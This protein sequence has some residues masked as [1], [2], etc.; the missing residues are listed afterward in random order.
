MSEPQTDVFKATA[1]RCKVI[2]VAVACGTLTMV[3]ASYAPLG[4]RSLNIAAILAVAC[5]NA[6]LVSGYLMHLL[7]ERKAIL[8]VLAFTAVF[9]IGLMGL[10]IWAHGD[11]PGPVNR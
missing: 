6:F 7:N 2:F 4:S 9:F 10:S 8:T 1:N 3:A 11:V 5:V